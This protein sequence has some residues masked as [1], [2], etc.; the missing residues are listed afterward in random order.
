METTS[1]LKKDLDF[2][3]SQILS[4]VSADTGISISNIISKSRKP[5]IVKARALLSYMCRYKLSMTYNYIASKL[6]IISHASVMHLAN[7]IYP[8]HY[9]DSHVFRLSVGRMIIKVSEILKTEKTVDAPDLLIAEI[10][11]KLLQ[12]NIVTTSIVETLKLYEENN[13]VNTIVETK[14]ELET[15]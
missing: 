14:K 6:N 11:D 9:N 15:T 13:I 1:N 7:N 3:F 8:Q 4:E 5:E 10:R 2:L 12:L